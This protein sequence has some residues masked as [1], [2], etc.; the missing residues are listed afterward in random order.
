MPVP[1]IRKNPSAPCPR[2]APGIGQTNVKPLPHSNATSWAMQ[3]GLH[4]AI[5]RGCGLVITQIWV[6]SFHLTVDT[7]ITKLNSYTQIFNSRGQRTLVTGE[8]LALPITILKRISL[9]AHHFSVSAFSLNK[10]HGRSL[11]FPTIQNRQ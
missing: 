10:S 7:S 8:K 1:G 4:N 11:A 2:S 5:S 9:P 3:I 6:A